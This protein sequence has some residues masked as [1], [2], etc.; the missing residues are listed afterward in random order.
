LHTKFYEGT[1]VSVNVVHLS[2]TPLAGA[3]IRI[4]DALN[5][6][7]ACHARLINLHP[8]AYGAR[9]FPEDLGW[10]SDTEE[11]RAV[12]A[13]ADILHLHHWVDVEFSPFGN[14][15]KLAPR[16]QILRHFHSVIESISMFTGT[17]EASI[18]DDPL[19]QVV[20]PHC[21]ERDFPNARVVPNL[22]PEQDAAYQPKET[23]SHPCRVFFSPTLPCSFKD[24]RWDTKGR[25]E[26]LRVLRHL[27]RRRLI[28]VDLV[29][30]VPFSE[31]MSRKGHSDLVVDDIV[32]G[33]FHLTSLEALAQGKPTLAF[34]DARSVSVISELTGASRLPWVNVRLE[35][36]A[37]VIEALAT[38]PDLRRELGQESRQ[39]IE[40]WYAEKRMVR[41]FEAVYDELME[42]GSLQ[43]ANRFTPAQEWLAKTLNDICWQNR[44]SRYDQQMG[45]PGLA[46]TIQAMGGLLGRSARYNGSRILG[47]IIGAPARFTG[48]LRR[49]Y[50]RIRQRLD[51]WETWLVDNRLERMDA[52]R[53]DL[54]DPARCEFHLD[55]YRFASCY[56]TDRSVADI[57]CGTGYGAAHLRVA[58]ATSVIGIDACA[59][60]IEYARRFHAAGGI[61]FRAG[62]AYETDLPGASLDLVVSFETI[63]H[64]ADENGLLEEFL[65]ILKP[66]GR[67]VLSTPNDWGLQRAPFHVR[68]YDAPYLRTAVGRY[69]AIEAMFNQNSGCMERPENRGLPRGIVE[70][71]PENQNGAECF[72]LVASKPR[73][74]D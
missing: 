38:D 22:V 44:V 61:S 11:C 49:L 47:A 12:L 13:D 26:V 20:I 1:Y 10:T 65:R 39:W 56:A 67:L 4:V 74:C 3:P 71:T 66:G 15:R 46:I 57:A 17:D 16:A 45:N 29:E 60:G 50:A 19:P 53:K 48:A 18:R 23:E 63:E 14:L 34:L 6:H 8:E 72:I 9:R 40:Q 69:F 35:D 52:T 31:A 70:T 27:V 58:G 62:S 55:R 33:A 59:S 2:L 73:S 51:P 43:R 21:A 28:Q 32:T 5:R 37:E 24:A 54:F 42:T 7:T 64:L 25:P 36:A 41:H 68:N 30:G